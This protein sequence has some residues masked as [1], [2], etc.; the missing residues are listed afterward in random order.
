MPVALGALLAIRLDRGLMPAGPPLWQA[1]LFMGVA[2][3]MTAFPVLARILADTG[4]I[5][6]PLGARALSCAA[7]ADVIVWAAVGVVV[8]AF[9]QGADAAAL[10]PVA[11]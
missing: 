7:I 1:A 9:E 8:G 6:T 3:A 4:L 5:A 2:M 11:R 10:A